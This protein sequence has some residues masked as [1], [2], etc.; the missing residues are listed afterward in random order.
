MFFCFCFFSVVT[1]VSVILNGDEP[2][3]TD[4]VGNTIPKPLVPLQVASPIN[5][6]NPDRYEFYTF[7]D[8]GEL[9]KRLMTLDEIQSIVANGNGDGAVI[10]SF[11]INDRD[12]EK[13]VHDIVES[14]QKVLNKEVAW[15]KNLTNIWS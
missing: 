10:H 6:L 8:N 11:P 14:V 7:N 2:Q 15:K 12:P 9:V 5:L 1:S 4:A 3:F 13:N